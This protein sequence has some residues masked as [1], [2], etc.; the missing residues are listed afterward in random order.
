M[1]QG[2]FY[3]LN[4]Q[5][6]YTLKVVMLNFLRSITPAFMLDFYHH[7]LAVLADFWYGHPSRKLVVIGVTGTNG[8]TT[9]AYFIAKV[10]E[11][12]GAK[13]GCAT[14]ALFKV[15]DKEWL[16]SAKMTMPGRFALQK[17]LKQMVD[18]GCEYAVIE[19]SSQGITQHRHEKIAYDIGV[20][21][22]LTP[23][24]IEAHGGFENYKQ[25][26][27]RLFKHLS[28][29]P[30]KVV[31][32]QRAPRASVLNADDEHV[33][34]FAV[35]GIAH[36]LRYGLEQSADL[37]ARNIQA[38]ACGVN[39]DLVLAA[40]S[41]KLDQAGSLPVSLKI[42]GRVNVYN[43]LAALGVA[44]VCGVDLRSA[45]KKLEAVRSVP[46]RFEL[47]DEGQSWQV[48]VD[49]APEPESL[50]KLY[51]TVDVLKAER[52]IH[53]LGSCGGGRDTARRAVLGEMAGQKAEVVIVTNEDPYDEEPMS[54]IRQVAEGAVKTG[55]RQDENLF[56][57]LDRKQAIQKAMELARP[58]DLVLM[59]GKG[60]EQF[61][62][63]EKGRKI[64]WDEREEA[65]KVIRKLIA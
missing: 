7:F 28:R 18:A 19:T 38:D 44:R 26:K 54:I 14:T 23:E 41:P 60:C 58:G 6:C 35:H 48:M 63:A 3:G 65:K 1:S 37:S 53:V 16:N 5:I 24:H 2:W 62:C 43:A 11:A 51:E 57:I 10:L 61:I 47:I 42:L 59:T 13:T 52:I 33:Q 40:Q 12:E 30:G 21:T 50:K 25:A 17:L 45:A 64:P 4:N 31:V 8:K 32:W 46:G 34:D 9:T 36:V 22:N 20:F 49:Y 56:L 55:K 15:A 39:F 29:L 27:I